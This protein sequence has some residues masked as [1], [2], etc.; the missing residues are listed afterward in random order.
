MKPTK[1]TRRRA[2]KTKLLIISCSLNPQ[3][4]SRL[5]AECAAK[6]A[7]KKHTVE[8]VDLRHF[9]LPHCDGDLA[10]SHATSLALAS[11]IKQASCILLAVPV[12]NYNVSAAAKNLIE[13]TGS[14]WDDKVVG[15]L[16]A[17]GG[18]MSYMAILPLANSMLLDFRCIVTPQIVYAD[19]TAFSDNQLT[20]DDISKRI[21]SLIEQMTALA[22][23]VSR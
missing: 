21:A 5:L 1:K 22:K 16:M 23:A 13:C 12:Y 18:K 15:F 3:S 6:F 17:A 14:A 2:R 7:R 9:E 10:E 20:S 8:L 11:K 19:K 4:R